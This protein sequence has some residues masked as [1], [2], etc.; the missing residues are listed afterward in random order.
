MMTTCLIVLDHNP[1]LLTLDCHLHQLHPLQPLPPS[2]SLLKRPSSPLRALLPLSAAET[3]VLSAAHRARITW[4]L[5]FVMDFRLSAI[6]FRALIRPF[7]I[8]CINRSRVI[9]YLRTVRF[10][11]RLQSML[12]R[13]KSLETTENLRHFPALW[14]ALCHSRYPSW[15]HNHCHPVHRMRATSPARHP[16]SWFQPARLVI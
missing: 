11:W 4:Q 16:L 8:V 14:I 7:R 1:C 6:S 3:H 9:N 5:C 10:P 13:R 15:P 12:R 2:H